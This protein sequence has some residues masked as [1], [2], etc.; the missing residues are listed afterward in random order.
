MN[1]EVVIS[2]AQRTGTLAVPVDAVR[3]T[4]ELPSAATAFGLDA[5]SVRA[6]LERGATAARQALRDSMSAHVPA[7][8]A[9]RAA[10]RQRMGRAGFGPGGAGPDSARRAAWTARMRERM[11]SG[12]GSGGDAADMQER[13]ARWR[14]RQGSSGGGSGGGPGGPMGP[15]PDG[16]GPPPGFS[17][18]A[19]SGSGTGSTKLQAV[20]VRTAHGLEPRV[21]RLG[22]S[23]F[24]YTEV[25]SGLKEGEEVVLLSVAEAAAARQNQKSEIK[26]R[27]GSM[28]GGLG[29]GTRT[30]S[31]SSSA[32][33]SSS[34]SGGR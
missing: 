19:Q 34:G 6:Q 24:D 17:G 15:P 12:G 7:D 30:S 28:P 2:I 1:G 26:Q 18:G 16:G 20:L 3:S 32:R 4:R 31:G 14:A 13:M 21:V 33:S 29:S 27:M 25:V 22:V 8:S 9:G 23:D 5:D 10:W 11:R